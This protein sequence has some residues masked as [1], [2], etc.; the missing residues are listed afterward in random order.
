MVALPR[1]ELDRLLSLPG[2]RQ[3]VLDAMLAEL[4]SDPPDMVVSSGTDAL[5]LTSLLAAELQLPMAYLRPK[6]KEHGRQQRVEGEL[7]GSHIALIAVDPTA[8]TVQDKVP[9]EHKAKLKQW[10]TLS[11]EMQKMSL[12]FADAAKTKNPMTI[13]TAAKQLNESCIK[14]HD[15]FR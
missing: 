1:V 15:V 4:R 13:H 9:P 2:E 12:E 14:C 7:R 8:E 6:P 11:K 10:Q 5:V 3:R